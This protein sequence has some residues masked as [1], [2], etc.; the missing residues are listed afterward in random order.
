V[1]LDTKIGF[2]KAFDYVWHATNA[3]YRTSEVQL[4][5]KQSIY[6][7]SMHQVRQKYNMLFLV[8][9]KERFFRLQI[10]DVT[11]GKTPRRNILLFYFSTC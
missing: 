8:P 7:I 2:K 11:I 1:F 3:K 10:N 5:Q 6:F 4:I 9:K